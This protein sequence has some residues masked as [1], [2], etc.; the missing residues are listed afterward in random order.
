MIE[1]GERRR[2]ERRVRKRSRRLG[3]KEGS[4]YSWST[5]GGGHHGDQLIM[6][7][8]ITLGHGLVTTHPFW[9]RAISGIYPV[10]IST[11]HWLDRW[12]CT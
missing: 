6:L 5:P 7:M 12:S 8:I 2:R 1:K 10:V 11:D 4:I 3:E 9:S